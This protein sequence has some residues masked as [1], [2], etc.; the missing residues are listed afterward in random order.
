MSKVII[1]GDST[2]NTLSVVRSLGVEK[3]PFVL[4]LKSDDDYCNVLR[5]RYVRRNEVCVIKNIE[6]CENLL[7]RIADDD[8]P[9]LICTFDEAAEWVDKH[10]E[11]LSHKYVTPCRGK[12]IG[13]LFNKD[14]QCKLAKE[15]GLTVPKTI[16]FDRKDAYPLTDVDYPVI[17]KPLYSTGG[18][19]SDIHICRNVDDFKK[20][21]ASSSYCRTFIIQ[22]F[23]EKEYELDCIGVVTEN[24]ILISGAVQKIRHYPHLIGAGAYGIFRPINE[25]DINSSGLTKFLKRSNYHGPF[26]VEFVYA[27]G[28]NYFMEVNF[29]NEG[30]AQVSTSAGA[31][32]HALYVDSSRTFNPGKVH[33]VY[34]MNYSIDYLH[35]KAGRVSRWRWWRDFMR[36]RCFI[37]F[38]PSDPM[39]VL[40]HYLDKI[41]A[42]FANVL[43]INKLRGGVNSPDLL[44]T[45]GY[46]ANFK[47]S[48]A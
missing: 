5:S 33:R 35:V 6:E 43:N 23:I 39:P 25:L 22:E 29:R 37:N 45:N 24:D 27:A 19:K 7:E 42:L 11:C 21:L 28:K 18:E 8:K 31:N 30:L 17:L 38:S 44:S 1:I 47:Y 26:S 4:L 2:H 16:I 10:E 9:Y 3:I 34:M 36:T 12:H 13:N 20:A 32:L 15:C 40:S 41:T 14:E 48:L 46:F